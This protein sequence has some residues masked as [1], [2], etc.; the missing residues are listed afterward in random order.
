MLIVL[1]KA[2]SGGDKRYLITAPKPLVA[3]AI[4]TEIP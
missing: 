4:T 2:L 3:L 1:L